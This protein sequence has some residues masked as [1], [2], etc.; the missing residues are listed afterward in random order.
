MK[1]LV[2]LTVQNFSDLESD[3]ESSETIHKTEAVCPVGILLC[4]TQIFVLYIAKFK[5]M[6]LLYRRLAYMQG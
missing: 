6:K 5:I 4:M 2:I 3:A 1:Q